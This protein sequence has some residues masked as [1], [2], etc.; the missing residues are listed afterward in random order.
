VWRRDTNVFEELAAATFST[1]VHNTLGT[2]IVTYTTTRTKNL[3]QY[4]TK[5]NCDRRQ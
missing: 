2:I 1:A 4:V 5:S 3:K